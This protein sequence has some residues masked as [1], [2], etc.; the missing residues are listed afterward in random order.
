MDFRMLMRCHLRMQGNRDNIY[1]RRERQ[2]G[3]EDYH[4]G[5]V[6]IVPDL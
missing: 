5:D 3:E 2:H 6:G 1:R 4:R